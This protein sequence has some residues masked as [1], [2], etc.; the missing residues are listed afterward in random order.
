MP[1][2]YSPSGS[3]VALA[4]HVSFFP[5]R[6]SHP[7]PPAATDKRAH[8]SEFYD[9]EGDVDMERH[10]ESGAPAPEASAAAAKKRGGLWTDK[11][12]AE[13][14]ESPAAAAMQTE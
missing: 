8:K 14:A 13:P 2:G 9:G 10:H 1:E 11:G 3:L 6:R 7:T 5:A 12:A 4:I